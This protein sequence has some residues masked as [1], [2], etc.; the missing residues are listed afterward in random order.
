MAASVAAVVDR[1]TA[2]AAPPALA[3]VDN[4]AVD[5]VRMVAADRDIV[6]KHC[7]PFQSF[8]FYNTRY[9][10]CSTGLFYQKS[11]KGIMTVYS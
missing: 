11:S 4:T 9:S 6:A 8:S 1:D 5:F 3:L 10:C 2:V 7:P